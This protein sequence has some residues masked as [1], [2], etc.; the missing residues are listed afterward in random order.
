MCYFSILEHVYVDEPWLE[1]VLAI[2]NGHDFVLMTC[3]QLASFFKH[4]FI[5][6]Q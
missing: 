5:N 6:S 1:E 2:F 4:F 3:H